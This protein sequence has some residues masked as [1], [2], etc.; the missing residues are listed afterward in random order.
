MNVSVSR[1]THPQSHF[2]FVRAQ[3]A[4][5]IVS[6]C[7]DRA[8]WRASAPRGFSMLHPSPWQAAVH[9][10]L[11]LL[12]GLTGTF[13]CVLCFPRADA[14]CRGSSWQSAGMRQ[15][16][17]VDHFKMSFVVWFVEISWHLWICVV[18]FLS[19]V[20]EP[21]VWSCH[22]NVSSQSSVTTK[23]KRETI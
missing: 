5:A 7:V 13:P 14:R 17:L 9:L 18:F 19:V 1:K 6:R 11:T 12:P 23:P 21:C 22:R 20:W 16:K 10:F 2:S 3:H 4:S 8:S 15:Q